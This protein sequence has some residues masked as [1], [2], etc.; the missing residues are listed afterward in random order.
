M[1]APKTKSA[2]FNLIFRELLED[3]D[4]KLTCYEAALVAKALLDE[5]TNENKRNSDIASLG[6]SINDLMPVDDAMEKNLFTSEDW[7]DAFKT[8]A[9]EADYYVPESYRQKFFPTVDNGWWN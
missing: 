8:V 9:F 4:C 7:V 5:F 2:K 1:I 3:R 6:R